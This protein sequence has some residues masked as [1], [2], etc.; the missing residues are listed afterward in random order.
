MWTTRQY[1]YRLYL[2]ERFL[3]TAKEVD[4]KEVE[5]ERRFEDQWL[6]ILGASDATNPGLPDNGARLELKGRV[7]VENI[8]GVVPLSNLSKSSLSCIPGSVL[9]ILRAS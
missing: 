6:Q 9:R 3:L 8:T 1:P 7:Y 2:W 4:A 5:P